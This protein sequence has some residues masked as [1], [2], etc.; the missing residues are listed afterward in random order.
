MLWVS[1][2]VVIIHIRGVSKTFRTALYEECAD[3][4]RDTKNVNMGQYNVGML[5]KHWKLCARWLAWGCGSLAKNKNTRNLRGSHSS[6]VGNAQH[7]LFLST[8]NMDCY[9]VGHRRRMT[10]LDKILKA[11]IDV[12]DQDSD[13]YYT[14]PKWCKKCWNLRTAVV[15]KNYTLFDSLAQTALYGNILTEAIAKKN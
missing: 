2:S 10:A 1:E 15:L 9:K 14:L 11:G 4:T 6:F 7:W 12:D 5:S 3:E 13:T 8:E